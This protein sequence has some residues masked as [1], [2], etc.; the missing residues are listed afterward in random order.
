MASTTPTAILSSP[1]LQIKLLHI[2]MTLDKNSTTQPEGYSTHLIYK[3]IIFSHLQ[4][5]PMLELNSLCKNKFLIFFGKF[6]VWKNGLPNSL[7]SLCR[8]NPDWRIQLIHCTSLTHLGKPSVNPC[9]PPD[10]EKGEEVIQCNA[11]S[12]T[13]VIAG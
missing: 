13:R 6:P 5:F 9:W 1:L 11:I 4:I 8:G 3:L 7:F 10:Q 12:S 2:K